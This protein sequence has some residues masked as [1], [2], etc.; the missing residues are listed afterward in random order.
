MEKKR[1]AVASRNL[2]A[3]ASHERWTRATGAHV[4]VVDPQIIPSDLV[5]GMSARGIHLTCVGSAIDGLIEFG[6]TCPTAA[7]AA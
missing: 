1:D 3:R 2:S 7:W 5:E 4:L 6:G